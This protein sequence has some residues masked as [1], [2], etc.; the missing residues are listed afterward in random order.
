M[1]KKFDDTKWFWNFIKLISN[2]LAH[3][4]YQ[5]FIISNNQDVVKDGYKELNE[6]DFLFYDNGINETTLHI[7]F[8]Y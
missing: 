2:V 6:R 7:D 8:T 5:T 3:E 1:F 4:T